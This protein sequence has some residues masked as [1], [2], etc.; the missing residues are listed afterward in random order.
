MNC[1]LCSSTYLVHSEEIESGICD[2]CW[3][4]EQV[5]LDKLYNLKTE[6]PPHP[7]DL[8]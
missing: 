6:E 2:A 7:V 1:V 4:K 3:Y 8:Y 5:R